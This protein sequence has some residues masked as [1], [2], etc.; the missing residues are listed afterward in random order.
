MHM[1]INIFV[2]SS[3]MQFLCK[4]H[5]S[6]LKCSQLGRVA[7]RWLGSLVALRLVSLKLIFRS[8]CQMYDAP[9]LKYE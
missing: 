7:C 5:T 3:V 2:G 1:F 8:I 4:H 6:Q 9:P